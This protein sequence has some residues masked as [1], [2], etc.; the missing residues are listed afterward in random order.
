MHNL[1]L[2]KVKGRVFFYGVGVKKVPISEVG[3]VRKTGDNTFRFS[4]N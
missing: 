2:G 1:R 3:L 4:L